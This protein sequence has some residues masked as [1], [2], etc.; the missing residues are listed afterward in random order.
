MNK[1]RICTSA[2]INCRRPLKPTF[3]PQDTIPYSLIQAKSEF[4]SFFLFLGV[5]MVARKGLI[6]HCFFKMFP[7][8]RT[9]YQMLRFA[10][11]SSGML[12]VGCAA[13]MMLGN[14]FGVFMEEVALRPGAYSKHWPVKQ[15]REL[16][17]GAK[18]ATAYH[19]LPLAKKRQLE[20]IATIIRER[21][22]ATIMKQCRKSLRP[23]LKRK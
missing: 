1:R 17:R 3:P 12:H 10:P 18:L 15:T 14:A 11:R 16:S 7:A 6:G 19:R 5:C 23:S 8:Q 2:C 20:K 22:A 21:R 4:F 9:M 13:K